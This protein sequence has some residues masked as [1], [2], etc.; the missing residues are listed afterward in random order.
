MGRQFADDAMTP[1]PI[2]VSRDAAMDEIPTDRPMHENTTPG[3]SGGLYQG[4]HYA[5]DFKSYGV[6]VASVAPSRETMDVNVHKA[7]RGSES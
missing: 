7:D 2:S 4:L 3:E 6:E 5:K 1:E